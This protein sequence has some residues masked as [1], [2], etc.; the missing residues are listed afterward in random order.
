[1][2][3]VPKHD[4]PGIG[5][6]RSIFL[7][8]RFPHILLNEPLTDVAAEVCQKLKANDHAVLLKRLLEHHV[9]LQLGL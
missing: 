3:I 8:L 9:F 6:Q 4:E 2:N 7:H 5:K 1:M